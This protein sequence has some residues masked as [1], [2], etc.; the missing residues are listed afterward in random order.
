VKLLKQLRM[1]FYKAD[2]LPTQLFAFLGSGET[3]FKGIGGKPLSRDDARQLLQEL[4]PATIEVR[5][6]CQLTQAVVTAA[7]H[8]SFDNWS[9]FFCNRVAKRFRT[10]WVVAKNFRDQHP[11][12]IPA[13]IGRHIHVNRPMESDGPGKMEFSSDRAQD[14]HEQ[15]LAALRHATGKDALPCDLLMEFHSQH[16]NET[17]EI[18]TAGIDTSF[19]G[20]LADRYEQIRR[21]DPTLPEMGIEPLHAIRLTA[22]N[23]KR[24]GSLRPDVAVRALHIEI[25]REFRQSDPARQ[26]MCRAIF[27]I[28]E[29][30]LKQMETSTDRTAM[31]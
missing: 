1:A 7:P 28:V 25:P 26:Q 24:R 15:Y 2:D 12:T 19:A 10:G 6:I 3:E 16:R 14:V 8:V 4:I 5:G 11:A 27:A 31:K 30:A 23:T 22:E 13:A 21:K 29:A 17:L 9:E 20:A 18:A